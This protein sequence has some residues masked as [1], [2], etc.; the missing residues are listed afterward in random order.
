MCIRD[1]A[2]AAASAAVAQ[3]GAGRGNGSCAVPCALCW[4][5]PP[6]RTPAKDAPGVRRRRFFGGGVRGS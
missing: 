5:G 2:A 1:R 4:C 6:P 3:L